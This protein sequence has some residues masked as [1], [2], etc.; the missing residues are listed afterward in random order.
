MNTIQIIKS[1]KPCTLY[2]V[3][4]W[5][6]ILSGGKLYLDYILITNPISKNPLIK[7]IY[8]WSREVYS[9]KNY[10]RRYITAYAYSGIHIVCL[11]INLITGNMWTLSNILVNLYPILVNIYIGYR[12][13]R[14]KAYN[15]FNKKSF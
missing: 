3:I 10:K 6:F 13:W 2:A 1:K 15:G 14:I 7:F 11:N 12:C 5:L 4:S 8:G 9:A